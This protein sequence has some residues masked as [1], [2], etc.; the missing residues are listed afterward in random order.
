SRVFLAKESKLLL[1]KQPNPVIRHQASAF[2][3][4]QVHTAPTWLHTLIY[5]IFKN[6]A[7]KTG[8]KIMLYD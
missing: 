6:V 1:T 2:P 3:K 5:I 4:S 7:F 8:N